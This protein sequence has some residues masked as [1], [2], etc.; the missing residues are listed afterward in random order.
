MHC[1]GAAAKANGMSLNKALIS[2]PDINQPLLKILYKFQQSLIAVCGDIREMFLRVAVRKEDHD[3]QRFLWRS[4]ESVETYVVMRMAFGSTFS[5]T[6][7][8]HV[9][10]INAKEYRKVAECS[11]C[12][13]TTVIMLLF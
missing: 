9:K 4:G 1:V 13:G 8:R 12:C 6:L 10:N 11:R 5:P 3:C 7:A 2:G